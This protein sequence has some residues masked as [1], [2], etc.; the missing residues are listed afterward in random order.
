[1]I[2]RTCHGCGVELPVP[3]R[4]GPPRKWCSERCRKQT[5]YTGTCVD[6]SGKT[7]WSGQVPPHERC[8]PCAAAHGKVWT[9]A[10]IIEAIQAWGDLHGRPPSAGDWNVADRP[11]SSSFPARL[12]R[13]YNGA[14]S[15][16]HMNTVRKAF[17]L[18][19]A[20]IAAAGFEPRAHDGAEPYAESVPRTVAAYRE[21]VSVPEI[22]RREGVSA[23]AIY[24]RLRWAEEPRNRQVAA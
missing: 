4:P 3:E 21:G 13:F 22:A 14:R 7:G 12:D 2:A 15:W 6:C 9:D 20:A 1:M 17:G 16:P 19:N 24:Q 8:N 23:E 11:E 5:L 10:A 18:W